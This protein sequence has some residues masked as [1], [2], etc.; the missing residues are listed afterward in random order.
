MCAIIL[1]WSTPS[2]AILPAE[3][4]WH[5]LLMP[6][7]TA[8]MSAQVPEDPENVLP[9]PPT[10]GDPAMGPPPLPGGA[11]AGEVAPADRCLMADFLAKVSLS[12]AS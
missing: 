8:Q 11:P 4:R 1:I 12:C 9:L 10:F 3:Q 6:V 5:Q 2:L 7:N